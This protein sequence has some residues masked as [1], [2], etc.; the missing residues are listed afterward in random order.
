MNLF[1]H[2]LKLNG[3]PIEKAMHYLQHLKSMDIEEFLQW[4]TTTAWS[5]VKYHYE[6]NDIYRQR[7][8]KHIPK[9]W[10]DLPIITKK[11]L[12]RPIEQVVT[13]G[14]NLKKCYISNTSGSSGNPFF[15]AKDKY[16]HAMTW[17]IIID[18]YGLYDINF[19]NKQ[20]RFYGIPKE[21]V[22]YWKEKVKD[23]TMN[24]VRFSVFDLST[25]MLDKFLTV[26]YN[27]KFTYLYGYTNSLV[28]FARYLIS[29]NIV[30]KEVCPSI[31]VC[32]S[33]SELCIQEDHLLLEQGFGVKHIREYGVS[34][35]CLTAFDN[36]D[37]IWQL[38]EETLYNEIIN[39][40][41]IAQP[42]GTE[43]NIA[44]TSLFNKAF[45]IIRYQVGDIAIIKDRKEGSI[46]RGL[47]KLLGRT[48]DTAL[49]PSGKVAPGLTFYYISRS[50]LESSNGVLKEF[51]IRQTAID[52]FV[53]EIV[54]DRDLTKEEVSLI[55]EKITLYLE[56]GLH[57][58]ISRKDKIERP[59]S[60]KL[61]HF[62]SELNKS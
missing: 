52:D 22:S 56:P 49:L 46:Y 29:R 30:L 40:N 39:K 21:I 59:T 45:P 54:A 44:S 3:F 32:I 9:D 5:Q 28:L 42:L 26:F 51:I 36:P 17:A 55:K 18:R 41:G 19:S 43:G 33:T 50:V 60:G 48:N 38:T 62:Y 31:K 47:D 6:F 35:T 57:I 61:K 8:G 37:R 34:E 15:F 25:D 58:T 11:D 16:A 20:A 13:K 24:R 1:K 53:F 14:I 2:I 27:K 23:Y 4:Q 10:D 12:Q 7:V